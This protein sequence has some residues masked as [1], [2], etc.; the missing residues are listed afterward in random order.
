MIPKTANLITPKT[1][2]I[3]DRSLVGSLAAFLL[4]CA[5]WGGAGFIKNRHATDHQVQITNTQS[6]I[7]DVRKMLV[8]VAQLPITIRRSPIGLKAV[9]DFQAAA[10]EAANKRDCVVTEF[11]AA[12]TPSPFLSRFEKT[13]KPND[14]SQLDVRMNLIGRTHDIIATLRAVKDFGIPFEFGSIDLTR[15]NVG[16]N[17]LATIDAKLEIRV[18]MKAAIPG[19]QP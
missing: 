6:Q 18:L 12:S 3:L 7:N 17:G 15:K 8:Q 5:Y 9:A 11:Q 2:R 10:E 13:P 1:S 19:V 4:L 16:S 14:W